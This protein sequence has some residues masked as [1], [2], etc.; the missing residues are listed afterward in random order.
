MGAANEDFEGL[1]TPP[2]PN[3][4]SLQ[5]RSSGTLPAPHVAFVDFVLRSSIQAML[6]RRIC[7]TRNQ[8]HD[9][10]QG[11]SLEGRD[12]GRAVKIRLAYSRATAMNQ[13]RISAQYPTFQLQAFLKQARLHGFLISRAAGHLLVG[14]LSRPLLFWERIALKAPRSDPAFISIY[15]LF[16]LSAKTLIL[17]RVDRGH[18][19]LMYFVMATNL[20]TSKHSAVATVLAVPELL[21]LILLQLPQK[22]LLL[23]QRTSR[24]FRET[25]SGSL[26]CQRALFF[27]ADYKHSTHACDS[28]WDSASDSRRPENNRLLLRALPG[29]YPTL[30]LVVLNDSSM[31]H[32]RDSAAFV[33]DGAEQPAVKEQHTWTVCVSYPSTGEPEVHHPSVKYPEASWKRMLMCQPP[34]TALHL[35]RRWQRSSNAAI[36]YHSE[37]DGGGGITMGQFC[38]EASRGLREG[39]WHGSYAGIDR[40]WHFEGRVGESWT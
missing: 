14:L 40:D 38:E 15:A 27:A 13:H 25:I 7:A 4:S 29:S 19:P 2:R 35:V 36:F 11:A 10:L 24:C 20:S 1:K 6:G 21:E 18:P 34:T 8:L 37:E 3:P 17:C 39:G 9:A 16:L 5:H 28:V 12:G 33:E 23:S 32:R 31:P 26:R 22:D 30:T